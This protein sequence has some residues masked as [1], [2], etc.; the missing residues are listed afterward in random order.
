MTFDQFKKE[1][2][3]KKYQESAK[4]WAQCVALAKLYASEVD[5]IQLNG[6]SWSAIQW[7]WTGSPFK[8]LPYARVNYTGKGIPP[9]GS[10]IFFSA[11]K[12]NPYWHVA[13]AGQCNKDEIR[14]IEQNADKGSGTGK[15]G[16]AITIRNYPYS[17]WKTGN[18]L[19]WYTC[20][21][22]F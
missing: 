22:Q 13:I 6:F 8:L 16:D 7:W 2:E 4:F 20:T 12:S 3:G 15:W 21:M 19:W 5:G 10:I 11:T 14:V 18:V 9:R 1:R 17:G